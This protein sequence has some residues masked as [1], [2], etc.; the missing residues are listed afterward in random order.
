M[1]K[2]RRADEMSR[3]IA[4]TQCCGDAWRN[5]GITINRCLDNPVSNEFLAVQHGQI[6]LEQRRVCQSLWTS[7]RNLWGCNDLFIARI[8]SA[9]NGCRR[10]GR[11]WGT[12]SINRMNS[13]SR[14]KLMLRKPSPPQRLIRG[15]LPSA[16]DD[17]VAV[18]PS[19]APSVAGASPG[20]VVGCR[21]TPR[22]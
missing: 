13:P 10:M 1:W 12:E 4:I 20:T 6:H 5:S 22:V 9:M 16:V 11:Q 2:L 21:C 19:C 7:V 17:D 18:S 3:E 15:T 14:T 8:W